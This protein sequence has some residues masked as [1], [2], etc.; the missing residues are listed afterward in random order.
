MVNTTAAVVQM[1]SRDDVAANLAAAERLLVQ[2]AGAGAMLAVLPE[3]FAFMGAHE[4]DKL[5][6]AEEAGRGTIQK[7]LARCAQQLKLWIVGGTIPLKAPDG[8]VFA[9][10]LVFNSSGECVARY[11]KIHLFDVAVGEETYRESASIAPGAVRAVV[12]DTPL[13]RLGLSVCY[14]LRFPELFRALSQQ[15]AE[16]LCVPSAFTARTGAAHWD[17]L[18]RTRAVE[19]LCQVLAPNQCGEHPGG[20]HT[21]GHSMIVDAWGSVLAQR[22]DGEGVVLAE[23]QRAPREHL[24]KTFPVLDHRRL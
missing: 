17:I 8:R 5:A 6:Q 12:V 21:H 18:L 11:D 19:N 10:S 7:F 9:A 4:K 2:A 13:G 23:I 20:R 15:G 14:D 24:R 3:N 22:A 1:N 16:I